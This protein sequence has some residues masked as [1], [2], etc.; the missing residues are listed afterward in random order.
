MNRQ[1]A[2]ATRAAA[3]RSQGGS[4]SGCWSLFGFL[5]CAYNAV[6]PHAAGFLGGGL[7]V[8]GG[9]GIGS[10]GEA[11]GLTS[12]FVG[13]VFGGLTVTQDFEIYLKYY[14]MDW[15]TNYSQTHHDRKTQF[16]VPDPTG[17]IKDTLTNPANVWEWQGPHLV[18]EHYF[19]R[20]VGT[21]GETAIRVVLHW[22]GNIFKMISGYPI[23]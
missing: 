1:E 16:N 18:L 14:H 7:A 13:M 21:R 2:N 12:G 15:W 23:P 20:I 9:L 11:G 6:A 3:E 5:H 17:L 10:A 19:D 22:D 8:L 4:G